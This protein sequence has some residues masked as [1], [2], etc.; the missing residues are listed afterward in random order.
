MKIP[1]V[2]SLA[3]A[4][5]ATTASAIQ[6]ISNPN[7]ELMPRASAN[8]STSI[9]RSRAWKWSDLENLGRRQ[10]YWIN[11]TVNPEFSPAVARDLA[12]NVRSA[13]SDQLCSTKEDGKC[14]IGGCDVETGLGLYLCNYRPQGVDVTCE[15][16]GTIAEE[17]VDHWEGR[18]K[19]GK[20]DG[21]E[22]L[23]TDFTDPL[24]QA[25]SYWSEDASW[26]V[27]YTMPCLQTVDFGGAD[28]DIY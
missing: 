2:L 21:E 10:L 8:G 13:S 16:F 14:I 5:I 24:V 12:Q 11:K 7:P 6:H 15:V 19:G 20:K 22:M 17:I 25:Y 28:D 23:V 1:P 9:S 4:S 27:M 26:V 18:Q 3:I